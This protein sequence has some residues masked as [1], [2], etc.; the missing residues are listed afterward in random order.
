LDLKNK[1]L[2]L[3]WCARCQRFTKKQ[4]KIP[5]LGL[6]FSLEDLFL[7]LTACDS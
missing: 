1:A 4:L 3:Y 5:P 2:P 7:F 6:D